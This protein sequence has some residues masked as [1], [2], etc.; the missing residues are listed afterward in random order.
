VLPPG[1]RWQH[2]NWRVLEPLILGRHRRTQ[3]SLP[4]LFASEREGRSSR[5]RHA[6]F[7]VASDAGDEFV[8]VTTSPG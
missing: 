2:S 6:Q 4:C 1:L 7:M 5:A 8:I 3:R